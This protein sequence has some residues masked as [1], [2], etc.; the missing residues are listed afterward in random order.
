M[1][2]RCRFL[3]QGGEF[4]SSEGVSSYQRRAAPVWVYLIIRHLSPLR[5]LYSPNRWL[6]C[7]S[8]LG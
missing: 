5:G 2:V 7:D 4:L 3:I 1:P 6:A 8:L